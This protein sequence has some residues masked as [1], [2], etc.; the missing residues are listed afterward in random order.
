MEL[1]SVRYD[2]ISDLPCQAND[3]TPEMCRCANEQMDERIYD[4]RPTI[5][6]NLLTFL[7]T[8]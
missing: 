5:R 8:P 3:E 6:V 1:S 4:G 7:A 2:N